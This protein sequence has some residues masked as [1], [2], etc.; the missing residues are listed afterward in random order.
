[1][2]VLSGVENT[3]FAHWTRTLATPIIDSLIPMPPWM[4][5]FYQKDSFMAYVYPL[6]VLL[7]AVI[8]Y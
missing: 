4:T 3:H 2:R 8:D 7:A 6:L 1:M 5:I